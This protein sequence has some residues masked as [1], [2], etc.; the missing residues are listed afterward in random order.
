MKYGFLHSKGFPSPITRYTKKSIQQVQFGS[1]YGYH[2][3]SSLN[4]TV[5]GGILSQQRDNESPVS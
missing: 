1:K 4:R 5:L 3:N 2:H